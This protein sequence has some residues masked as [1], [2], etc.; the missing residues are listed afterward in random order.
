MQQC[1]LCLQDEWNSPRQFTTHVGRHL[2]QIALASLP[3][4]VES[5]SETSSQP[6]EPSSPSQASMR[7][8]VP[9]VSVKWQGGID[10]VNPTAIDE[11]S[12]PPQALRAQIIPSDQGVPQSLRPAN[13]VPF[14]TTDLTTYQQ[15][16]PYIPD[17]H[18]AARHDHWADGSVTQAHKSAGNSLQEALP[19]S[20]TQRPPSPI[21]STMNFMP[22]NMQLEQDHDAPHLQHQVRQLLSEV[23]THATFSNGEM[24]LSP[25]EQ[26]HQYGKNG[27]MYGPK[28][29]YSEHVELPSHPAASQSALQGHLQPQNPSLFGEYISGPL[30]PDQNHIVFTNTRSPQYIDSGAYG[31][32][33]SQIPNAMDTTLQF[34]PYHGQSQSL[35]EAGHNQYSNS[36]LKSGGGPFDFTQPTFAPNHYGRGDIGV[37]AFHGSNGPSQGSALPEPFQG[38][39]AKV[40][41]SES[42]VKRRRIMREQRTTEGASKNPRGSGMRP[43]E[44]PSAGSPPSAMP[45]TAQRGERSRP[46]TSKGSR[47]ADIPNLG[48]YRSIISKMYLTEGKTLDEVIGFLKDVHNVVAR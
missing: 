37:A 13:E 14:P 15:T 32:P 4:D 24:V 11:T 7:T 25:T 9:S 16:H 40:P 34:A 41:G 23:Q 27:N 2:E 35:S 43:A 42:K 20:Y 45:P 30:Y 29:C 3:R 38:H 39:A 19:S 33:G 48:A 28:E 22:E 46:R 10:T 12:L 36:N 47:Q 26:R 21:Y 31:G 5:D 1:P 18:P 8:Q 6:S 17:G 44:A